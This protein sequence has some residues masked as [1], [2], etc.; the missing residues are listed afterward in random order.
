ALPVFE[1]YLRTLDYTNT[2]ITDLLGRLEAD[3]LLDDTIVVVTADHGEGFAQHHRGNV[4]HVIGHL[5]QQ[6]V[7]IPLLIRVPGLPGP[8]KN[9]RLG[10]TVDLAPT[11]FG[12]LG[13]E[14]PDSWQGQD[15]LSPSYR[16]RPVLIFSRARRHG[17]GIVDGNLTWFR[18]E[19]TTEEH[20]FDIKADPHEQH[21]LIHGRR[22]EAEAY[23]GIV[24][25]W[26]G[27]QDERILDLERDNRR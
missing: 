2:V 23:R 9:P 15:L 16:P 22:R 8:V 19:G 21:D 7:N 10:S 4:N 20:L 11:L 13:F 5:Y 3:G 12:L 18:F 26:L 27:Y 1:R 6:N 14:A 17:S 24:R 25:D